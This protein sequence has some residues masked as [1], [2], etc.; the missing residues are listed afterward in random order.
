MVK[1]MRYV[2]EEITKERY[3]SL[4]NM[5]YNEQHKELFPTGIP[6]SWEMGYGYYGHSLREEDGRCFAVYTL[7]GSCD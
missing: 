5:T 4:K 1:T 7:G 6:V 3:N 2:K